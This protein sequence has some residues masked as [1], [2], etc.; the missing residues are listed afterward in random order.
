[1]THSSALPKYIQISEMLIREITAGH[2]PDGTRLPPERQ[3]ADQH[4]ISVGTLRKALG[5]LETKGLL[6][7]IQGSGNY[8][9]SQTVTES[10]YT[11]FR[12]ELTQGGGLPTACVI[13]VDRLHKPADLP[14]F[15]S[16]PDAHR[17]RRLR[18]LGGIPAAVEE[19]WLDG[20]FAKKINAA[21]LL[22]SLYLFYKGHLGL[23]ISQVEDRI[24][25]A[26]VPNWAPAAL[27][28]DHGSPAGFIERISWSQNGQPSEFSRTWYNHEKARYINRLK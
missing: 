28:M 20:T 22:E 15:G 14:F 1:M 18:R 19:I 23:I 9:K 4:G 12:L 3:M 10:I 26:P 27:G 16:S 7:R 11:F 21:D 25:V 17:I 13:S 2:L 6:H 24:G 8:I 5:D